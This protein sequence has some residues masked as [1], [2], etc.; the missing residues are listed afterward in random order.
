M[1]L[2]RAGLP[3]QTLAVPIRLLCLQH[4]QP[5]YLVELP[6]GKPVLYL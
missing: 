2:H 6:L 1:I 3:I 5:A 4:E